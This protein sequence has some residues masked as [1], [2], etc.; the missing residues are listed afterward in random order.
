MRKSLV[1]PVASLSDARPLAVDLDP[2]VRRAGRRARTIRVAMVDLDGYLVAC[3]RKGDAWAIAERD[4]AGLLIDE[5]REGDSDVVASLAIEPDAWVLVFG[6]TEPRLATCVPALAER[7][8]SQIEERIALTATV[9]MSASHSGRDRLLAAVSESMEAMKYKLVRGGNRV[10]SFTHI[11]PAIARPSIRSVDD[12][13]V[14]LIRSEDR[15]GVIELLTARIAKWT[16][17]EG[18]TPEMVGS[19]AAAEILLV[20]SVA[21]EHRIADG[22]LSWTEAFRRVSFEHLAALSWIYEP[23]HLALWLEQLLHRILPDRTA[24][25]TPGSKIIT[26]ATSYIDQ[27]FANDIG[28]AQVARAIFVSPYYLSHLFRGELDTTFLRYLTS[29]R[30]QAARDLLVSSDE[31]IERTAQQVGYSSVKRF[32]AV[33]KRTTG[34]TPAAFRRANAIR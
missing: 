11:D 19:N 6:G 25:T 10:I 5:A 1:S 8:R 20:M 2:Q 16:E 3:R 23:E 30:M 13:L 17:V 4:R 12:E 18:A 24:P 34:M 33:F 31:T 14:K 27:Q 29:T 28:L 32:R 21:T 15:N 22:S 26:L 9:S 7:I